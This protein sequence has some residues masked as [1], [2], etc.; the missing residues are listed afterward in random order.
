[1]LQGRA[2][3]HPA[4]SVGLAE[5]LI[6]GRQYQLTILDRNAT[7]RIT[8]H[9]HLPFLAIKQVLDVIADQ[10][11]ADI[12]NG[13]ATCF[14]GG[15]GVTSLH[16]LLHLVTGVATTDSTGNRGNLLA[17]TTTDLIT[18]QATH[19]RTYGRTGDLMLVLHRLLTGHRHVLADLPRRLDGFIDRLDRQHL[20]ILRATHQT[21]CGNSA[22]RGYTHSTQHR[23]HQH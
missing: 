12:G 4:A 21:V 16:I 3:S 1:V 14:G 13:I 8:G 19:Y 5:T 6:A 9:A 23:T 18:Q 11:L 22:T 2:D 7:A 15:V 10:L 20:G 17:R